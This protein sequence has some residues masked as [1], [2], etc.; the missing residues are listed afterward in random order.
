MKL[1]NQLIYDPRRIRLLK[2]FSLRADMMRVH[3]SRWKGM[4]ARH[5]TATKQLGF[6]SCGAG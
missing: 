3:G 1:L 2:I 4:D 6:N 5:F